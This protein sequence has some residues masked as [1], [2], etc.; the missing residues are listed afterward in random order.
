MGEPI[1][2]EERLRRLRR[3]Q[4][5][6]R[7][8]RLARQVAGPLWQ[9]VRDVVPTVYA[10]AGPLH[11]RRMQ[12]PAEELIAALRGEAVLALD[13]AM[14]QHVG[15]GCVPGGDA[16]VY[17]TDPGALGRLE[18]AGLVSPEPCADRVLVR[19]WPGPPRLFAV[20]VPTLPPHV[21][22][23]D[24]TLVVTRSH[25]VREII[26]ALGPR[27]DVLAPLLA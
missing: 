24:G 21:E 20:V 18:L 3:D 22:L 10:L 6:A 17:L 2:A 13:T 19:A 25:L 4:R 16:H 11:V 26:G 1:T 5:M 27:L 15:G 14:R 9:R 7:R 8:A 12:A 23:P